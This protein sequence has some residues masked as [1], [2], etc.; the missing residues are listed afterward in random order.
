[1][2]KLNFVAEVV[3]EKMLRVGKGKNQI[4]VKPKSKFMWTD[5]SG[6]AAEMIVVG[7]YG[8]EII[9]R[10]VST[11]GSSKIAEQLKKWSIVK[12][13]L[14]AAGIYRMFSSKT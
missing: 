1:M 4:L 3:A 6:K 13:A 11:Q 10:D 14:W 7:I 9:V 12:G 2:A 8:N 5:D